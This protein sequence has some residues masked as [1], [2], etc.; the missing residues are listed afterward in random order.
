MN[1]N[2]KVSLV[3]PSDWTDAQV[4]EVAAHSCLHLVGNG[5]AILDRF[6]QLNAENTPVTPYSH[7]VMLTLTKPMVDENGEEFDEVECLDAT[8]SNNLA[9]ALKE[10]GYPEFSIIIET[11]KSARIP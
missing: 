5:P 6:K 1:L 3:L 4:S 11:G 10:F 9:V 2:L 8:S 7:G